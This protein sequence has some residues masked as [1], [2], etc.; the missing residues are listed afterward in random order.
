MNEQTSYTLVFKPE[1][2]LKNIERYQQFL[3]EVR[4]EYNFIL[5]QCAPKISKHFTTLT[6]VINEGNSYEFPSIEIHKAIINKLIINEPK[7]FRQFLH[8][9]RKEFKENEQFIRQNY[10]DFAKS[11]DE[12]QSE[13]DEDIMKNLINIDH[14]MRD[15]RKHAL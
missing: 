13:V 6:G 2:L 5:K 12:F 8:H 1:P 7:H 14:Y 9:I 15:L 4:S 3:E 10:K 11:L